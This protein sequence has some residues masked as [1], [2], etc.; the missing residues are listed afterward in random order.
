VQRRG[1]IVE[2]M[3]CGVFIY[4]YLYFMVL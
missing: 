2:C 3:W 1:V 4:N